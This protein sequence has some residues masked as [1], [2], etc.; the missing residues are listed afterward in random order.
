[1]IPPQPIDVK[2]VVVKACLEF[3]CQKV[4][5]GMIMH[6]NKRHEMYYKN[7]TLLKELTYFDELT[8]SLVIERTTFNY[9]EKTFKNTVALLNEINSYAVAGYI[10]L[11]VTEPDK[12]K[13]TKF[14]KIIP[15]G[16][17]A[18][19]FE[20]NKGVQ[21]LIKNTVALLNEINSYAV[22]GYILLNVTEP[23]KKKVTK[24][25]KIIPN[26]EKAITFEFNQGVQFLK[27]REVE[28]AIV[29]LTSSLEK[30][31]NH[32]Q[33][34]ERRAYAY[35]LQERFEDAHMD[36]AKSLKLR[37]SPESFYTLAELKMAEGFYAEAA[38]CL[39]DAIN[40]ALPYQPI[41]WTSR[42][43]KGI[44][45][46]KLGEF[47]AA[48]TELRYFTKRDYTVDDPNFALRA[49]AWHAFAKSLEKIG[50]KKNAELALSKA[51]DLNT[52]DSKDFTLPKY[53]RI[54]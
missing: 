47:E 30:Y 10:L 51:T 32:F 3:G 26:G 4:Y 29:A 24:F 28:K 16:E 6:F 40:N 31:E 14:E 27:T 12:K 22:A 7:D 35:L 36:L 17:K 41:F 49:D 50:D 33:A 37:K 52:I 23:D 21:F 19:T 45:H 54:K 18:I 44:C 42:R 46:Y 5:D 2:K 53:M 9:Y 15:N 11:N 39:Q 48:T 13:V 38:E 8:F 1:M 20:F 43:L 25:E 34:L